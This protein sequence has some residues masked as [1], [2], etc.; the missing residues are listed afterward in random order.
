MCSLIF[1]LFTLSYVLYISE[2]LSFTSVAIVRQNYQK[3]I[4]LEIANFYLLFV[5]I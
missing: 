2:K 1:Y 5:R 3:S 4:Q